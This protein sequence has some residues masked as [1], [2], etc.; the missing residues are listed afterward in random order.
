[1]REM[2]MNVL[3]EPVLILIILV[4][5][6]QFHTTD[7]TGIITGSLWSNSVFN[8]VAL[9]LLWFALAFIAIMDNGLLPVDNPST[10]LELT[11]IQKALHLEYSGRNLALIEWG[12]TMRL[13][14]FLALLGD[15]VIARPSVSESVL[16]PL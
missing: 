6:L 4:L 5:A 8:A 15:L 16:V 7:L 11:M 1:S 12:E 14:F 13:T 10:H 9:L 2:F 3:A